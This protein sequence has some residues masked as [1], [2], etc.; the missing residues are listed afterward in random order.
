MIGP[1]QRPSGQLQ[2]NAQEEAASDPDLVETITRILPLNRETTAQASQDIFAIEEAVNAMPSNVKEI[3]RLYGEWETQA[4]RTREQNETARRKRQEEQEE[5]TDRLFSN[6]K[7]G[8]GD[9]STIE[10]EF[11]IA[12][13]EKQKLEH[14][15]EYDSF[16]AGVFEPTYNIIQGEIAFLMNKRAD[17]YDL[18]VGAVTGKDE[19]EQ[20]PDRA[21]LVQTLETFIMLQER[22]E[23]RHQKVLEAVVDRDRRYKKTVTQPL[24]AAGNI[25]EM[26]RMEAHFEEAEKITLLKAAQA[27][28]E[29]MVQV[30]QTI[31]EFA[32]RGLAATRE[33]IESISDEVLRIENTL[34]SSIMNDRINEV[35]LLLEELKIIPPLLEKL[36]HTA[37][38]LMGSLHTA[39]LGLHGVHYEVLVLTAKVD[40]QPPEAIEQIL[41]DKQKGDAR[42]QEEF[43]LGVSATREEDRKVEAQIIALRPRL[44]ELK[45]TATDPAVSTGPAD[46]PEHLDRIRRALEAAKIRN[47]AI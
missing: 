29:R 24:Y 5:E 30:R 13:T 11:R 35:D 44:E 43:D 17:C 22:I 37:E 34:P 19:L 45:F 28:E 7:I 32:T 12:E 16:V 8:Y 10:D 18:T 20:H 1:G 23:F 39:S 2:S 27:K 36:A 38:R 21:D 6:S 14:R 31:E 47:A 26:K 15:E 3:N 46:D 25:I 4:K 40:G 9:I 42:L 41:I 33:Y